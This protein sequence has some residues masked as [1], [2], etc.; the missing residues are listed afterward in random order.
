[1]TATTPKPTPKPSAAKIALAAKRKAIA[2]REDTRAMAQ[3]LRRHW[4]KELKPLAV[5]PKAD[6]A[7]AGL[8]AELAH[9]DGALPTSEELA[10][11]IMDVPVAAAAPTT[12]KAPRKATMPKPPAGRDMIGA[13]VIGE[14][15]KVRAVAL[16]K[17]LFK[18]GATGMTRLEMSEALGIKPGRE[19]R[20]FM[21]LKRT[22]AGQGNTLVPVRTENKVRFHVAAV[23][24]TA[25]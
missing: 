23:V 3:D 18:A 22:L 14:P 25:K 2:E 8:I 21:A 12:P 16:G 19:T 5:G 7:L 11:A 9:P 13:I 4:P 10:A 17:L 15:D 1:M 24:P 20:A 6:A